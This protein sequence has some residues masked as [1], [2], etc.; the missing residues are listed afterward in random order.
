MQSPTVS[1]QPNIAT[2][3]S[4]PIATESIGRLTGSGRK[5]KTSLRGLESAAYFQPL[6]QRTKLRKIN[7][8]VDA[9]LDSIDGSL[10]DSV[11]DSMDGSI[12]DSFE[13][14]MIDPSIDESTGIISVGSNNSR[15]FHADHMRISGKADIT[16]SKYEQNWKRF[17]KWLVDK[18]HKGLLVDG[19]D[20]EIRSQLF[21]SIR[22]PIS[23]HI[24]DSYLTALVH[25]ANGDLKHFSVPKVFWATLKYAHE[26]MRPILEIPYEMQVAW[27]QYSKGYKRVKVK[28]VVDR[29]L[30]A[31]EGKDSLSFMDSSTFKRRR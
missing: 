24:F 31:Y 8:P 26:Q 17:R 6:R 12:A 13:E 11:N 23:Q 20:L 16:W 5:R 2:P 10:D 7:R 14:S 21:T 30:S 9:E 15:M 29:G 19:K 3:G 25:K 28:Q 4:D 18:G 22:L 1:R 27:K